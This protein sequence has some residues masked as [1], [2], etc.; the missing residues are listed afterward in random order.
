MRGRDMCHLL[1]LGLL[2]SSGGAAI[3]GAAVVG[4]VQALLL[5][6]GIHPEHAQHF[7]QAEEQSHV[8]G[9]PACMSSMHVRCEDALTKPSRSDCKEQSTVRG[10][11]Q[12]HDDSSL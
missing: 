8:D 11:K 7:E 4:V 10:L 2:F 5:S 1:V 6:L 3:R 9:H 12:S